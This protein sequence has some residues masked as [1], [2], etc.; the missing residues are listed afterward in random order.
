MRRGARAALIPCTSALLPPPA[1]A[2]S[3]RRYDTVCPVARIY[4]RR[5]L[6]FFI[7]GRCQ[8]EQE[9]GP[10]ERYCILP[11]GTVLICAAETTVGGELSARH[12]PHP[13]ALGGRAAHRSFACDLCTS[14]VSRTAGCSNQAIMQ[15]SLQDGPCVAA[16]HHLLDFGRRGGDR[17]PCLLTAVQPLAVP[18][19]GGRSEQACI[20]ILL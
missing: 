15:V 17:L 8:P 10:L 1:L 20:R 7:D 3:D 14:A 6:I 11:R 12:P 4:R 16:G 2:L 18:R 13:G 5:R 19:D 9:T